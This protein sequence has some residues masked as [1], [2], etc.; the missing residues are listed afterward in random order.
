MRRR[1]LAAAGILA[2][3]LVAGA[4]VTVGYGLRTGFD[5]AA[6]DADLPDVIASFAPQRASDIDERVRALPN[7]AARSYRYAVDRVPLRFGDRTAARGQVE[8][9]L[10]GRRGYEIVAGRDL[11]RPGEVVVEQGVARAL[12]VGIGDQLVLGRAGPRPVV[13]IA[14]S[15]D[16]VAYPLASDARVYVLDRET[17]PSRDYVNTA[18]LWVHD[19][20]RTPITLTAARTVA[21]GLGRLRLITRTGIEVTIAQAAG[22]VIALLVAFAL[23]A[24]IAAATMLGAAAHG[25][26]Q[27]GLVGIGVR[28]ALGMTPRRVVAAHARRALAVAAPVGALGVAAGAALVTGPA[29]S[30]LEALNQGSPGVSVI[31]PLVVAWV[32]VCAVVTAAAALPAWRAARRPVTAL[33]RGADIS[34]P[35]R[36]GADRGLA[37]LGG[38]FAVA[39]RARWLGSV[40]TIAVCAGVVLLMLGL[41]SLLVRLRDDP[42][43]LGK[44]YGLTVPAPAFLLPTL[45]AIPGVAAATQRYQVAAADAFRIGQ[46]LQL[47]AYRGDHVRFDAPPLVAGRRLRAGDEAEVG[48]GLADAVGLR[49]GGRLAVLL[50]TGRELRLKVTGVVRGIDASGRLAWVTERALLGASPDTQGQSVLRLAPGADRGRVVD[51]L[52]ALG[53]VPARVGGATTRNAAFLGILAAVLRAVALLVGLVCLYAQLQALAM[54][55]RDRRGALAV[56]RVAG[57]GRR[58]VALLL[59][60]AAAAVA[61]PA[62]VGAVVLERVLLGPAVARLA[63]SYASLPLAPSAPQTAATVAGLLLVAGAAAAL[64]ARRLARE[65]VVAG[66]R[67]EA[68]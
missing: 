66:L 16:A 8:V 24:L 21:F 45:E 10:G 6:R 41:A 65:P 31:T 4:A 7:L 67:E 61:L 25:E 50:P 42:G 27:R 48:Q 30:L 15:P 57:G 44:R 53:L 17:D 18:L 36:R 35:P 1:R 33:L 51:R 19:R 26:V 5:R 28:R 37:L 55:A 20:S 56:L 32:V 62:A 47:I 68:G 59:G 29:A 52:E 63:A 14:R 34:P 13:G 46:P 23:I 49:P 58:D 40:A 3:A 11:R 54:T 2:A 39:A 12:R 43:L 9:L 38:R 64:V 60:G 22:I